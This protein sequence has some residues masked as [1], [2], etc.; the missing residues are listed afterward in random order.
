MIPSK[1]K[2]IRSVLEKDNNYYNYYRDKYVLELLRNSLKEPVSIAV[3]KKS[4]LGFLTNKK[5]V[6]NILAKAGNKC[7]TGSDFEH[8]DDKGIDFNVSLGQWG[9]YE[10]ESN[11]P[12]YQTSRSGLNLVLQLNFDQ[13][14]NQAYYKLISP[15]KSNHPFVYYGHPVRY[16][17]N[18]LTMSWARLDVDLDAGEV[19]IE[20]I[21]NDWL[22]NATTAARWGYKRLRKQKV[23]DRDRPD[24]Y[25][26][27]S[28][29]SYIKYYEEHLKKYIEIWAEATLNLAI[30]FTLRELGCKRIF[31]N[32]YE[33]GNFMKGLSDDYVQPPKSTYTKLPK[34]F[35]FEKT[36]EAPILLKKDGTLQKKLRTEGL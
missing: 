8:V 31:Y 7:V 19:L 12:W 20:E 32:T 5:V 6:R 28:I 34:R 15:R 9:G 10:Y 16:K 22:R 2:F 36:H 29:A 3:L 11:D 33:T 24:V 21:Q 1:L 23:K 13:A 14:H 17:K 4:R 26:T 27:T 18:Y 30:T 25:N 35:G